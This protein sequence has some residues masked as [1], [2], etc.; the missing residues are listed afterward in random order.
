MPIGH[1]ERVPVFQNKTL[2]TGLN[3][4]QNVFPLGECYR[5][6]DLEIDLAI[7]HSSEAG[8]IANGCVNILKAFTFKT[9]KSEYL[10][11]RI[12]GY[13]IQAYNTYLR[14]TAPVV[15]AVV[16]ATATYSQFLEINFSD[17]LMRYPDDTYLDSSRYTDLVMT[18]TMGDLTDLFTT[19]T[20]AALVM[21]A[22][23][24]INR[25]A[26][27]PRKPA[28]SYKALSML[29]PVNP[30]TITQFDI[31]RD[32]AKAVKRLFFHTAN[33]VTGNLIGQPY[34]GTAANTT[35]SDVSVETSIKVHFDHVPFTMLVASN[36]L[37]YQL[38]TAITGLVALDFVPGGSNAEAIDTT[39]GQNGISK[40]RVF[41][42]NGTLSNSQVSLMEESLQVLKP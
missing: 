11:D 9:S 13:A 1:G 2:V 30:A 40:F 17:P 10:Y 15:T 31:V 3:T 36:K 21:T 14:H 26:G 42:T 35:I 33:T 32:G 29:Q 37:A 23:C 5:S 20:G 22:S 12:P 8:V 24:Y 41:W 18:M 6:L 19:T 28:K 25:V 16:A 7:T 4:F 39:P 27:K 34:V 38:E